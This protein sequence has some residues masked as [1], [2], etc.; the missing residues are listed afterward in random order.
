MFVQGCTR[1]TI[2]A[3]HVLVKC[4]YQV[5]TAARRHELLTYDRAVRDAEGGREFRGGLVL[6]AE[7]G[8]EPVEIAEYDPVWPARFAEMRDRLAGALGV[9]ASRIDHVGSTAVPGLPAKP[10]IDI[11]VSVPEVDDTE[12]YRAP[13][14][15]LG[16]DLRYVEPGHRYFRPG[17]GVPRF[18]QVHVCGLGSAWERE[19]L[20]FRDFLRSHPAEAAAYAT[21]K[22]AAASQHLTDRIAYNDAKTPW[23]LAALQR[24]EAWASRTGWRP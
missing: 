2:L 12:T 5:R 19:H 14:E 16:I 24:A 22:R 8:L 18:W 21:M 11:Q 1:G 23:I 17:P 15:A 20:L 9:L 3:C 10:I 13:I 7:R 4:L 6:G